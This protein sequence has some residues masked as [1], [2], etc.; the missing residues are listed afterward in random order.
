MGSG[1]ALTVADL[2]EGIAADEF[3]FYDVRMLVL[4]ACQT[5][6]AKGTELESLRRDAPA[7]GRADDRRDA[8]ASNST[9]PRRG[10]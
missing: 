4:S 5:A 9:S 6:L 1:E 2:R 3:E 7:R 10:S 8:L